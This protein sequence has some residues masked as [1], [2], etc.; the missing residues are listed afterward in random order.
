MRNPTDE[1]FLNAL[2]QE[3]NTVGPP[4]VSQELPDT[5]P[6]PPP[7]G[8]VLKTVAILGSIIAA[9]HIIWALALIYAI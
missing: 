5:I 2:A 6:A 1:A 8:N 7:R 9:I 3:G 4:V